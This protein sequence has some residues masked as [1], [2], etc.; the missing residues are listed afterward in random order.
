MERK[1]SSP[2]LLPL[3]TRRYVETG[4]RVHGREINRSRGGDE[5]VKSKSRPIGLEH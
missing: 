3:D 2:F 5:A 1:A 4:V